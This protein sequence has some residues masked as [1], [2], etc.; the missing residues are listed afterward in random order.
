MRNLRKGAHTMANK[1]NHPKGVIY[2]GASRKG[3]PNKRT[4]ES[5]KRVEWVLSILEKTLEDDIESVNPNERVKLWNDL[6]EYI[7]PKLA[8]TEIDTGNSKVE[9]NIDYKPPTH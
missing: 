4:V 9:I 5:V 2:G 6:Q 1:T 3:K 7:R 8:R